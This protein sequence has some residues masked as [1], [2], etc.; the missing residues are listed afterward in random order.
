M[1]FIQLST[2]LREGGRGPSRRTSL[3]AQ[4]GDTKN[5]SRT[6]LRNTVEEGAGAGFVVTGVELGRHGNGGAK[7]EGSNEEL[8]REDLW[9]NCFQK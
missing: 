8:H 9:C 1:A 2:I 6:A 5:I 7:E 3:A 4:V